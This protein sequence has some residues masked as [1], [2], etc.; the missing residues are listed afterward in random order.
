MAE[1]ISL[2]GLEGYAYGLCAA[3]AAALMMLGVKARRLPAGTASLFGVLGMLLGVVCARALYC[4]VNWSEFVYSYENPWLMLRWFDGGLS[5]AG[6][7]MGLLAAAALT[8]RVM[9]IRFA[10]MMDA[11]CVPFGLM[12]AALRFGE[13]FTD[14]GVG[15]AGVDAALF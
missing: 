12:M 11:V 13:K 2:F 1:T 15:K 5:M 6:L 9:N 10:Q 3:A 8:A 4:A 14:L 7:I